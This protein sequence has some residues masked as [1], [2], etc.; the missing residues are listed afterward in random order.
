MY[1]RWMACVLLAGS[2]FG[3]GRL[4]VDSSQRYFEEDGKPWF[5]LGD[6]AWPLAVSYTAEE[7][8]DY[9]AARARL[10]F[11]IV[12]AALIWDGGTGTEKGP[13]PNPNYAGVSPWR[14]QNPLEPEEAYWKNVDTLVAHAARHGMYLGLLPAWGSYVVNRKM[15]TKENAEQYGRWLGAR[16]RNAPNIV[17]IVGG[18]RKVSDAPEIWPL[19]ARGLQEGDGGSHLITFHPMGGPP[20]TEPLHNEPWLA[21]D[22]IQTWA[23]YPSIPERLRHMYGLTPPKPVILGE[24]AYEEGPEYPTKPI[25][26]LVVRKQAYWAYLSG[27]SFTYGHNDMWRKNP[28]WR[29]SLTS[30]GAR[31]MSVL[32][33]IFASFDWWHLVPDDSIL[34]E[35]PGAGREQ[36]AAARSADNSWRLVYLSHA[37]PV[38]VDMRVSGRFAEGFWINPRDGSRVRDNSAVTVGTVKPPAGWED[39]LLLVRGADAK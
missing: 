25:T 21:A 2:V 37:G 9:L 12:Q 27:A 36:N 17:W 20:G 35:G 38:R 3:A 4:R 15:I 7:A 14:N 33:K 24:G 39:A 11:T 34:M 8:D 26:P 22:M 23:D 32:K 1:K 30:E 13:S 19:I 29:K 16:Y 18:D 6:T 28:T 31:D 10:G 5:W